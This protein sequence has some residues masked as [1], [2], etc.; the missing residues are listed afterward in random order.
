MVLLMIKENGD[1]Q[2]TR[3]TKL[4]LTIIIMG[5]S[6][7]VVALIIVIIVYSLGPWG[8]DDIDEKVTVNFSDPIIS[9]RHQH[10]VTLLDVD[11]QVINITPPGAIVRWE[12]VRLDISVNGDHWFSRYNQSLVLDYDPTRCETDWMVSNPV[13]CWYIDTQGDEETLNP[14]D[15]LRLTGFPEDYERVLIN[16][17]HNDMEL[18]FIAF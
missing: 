13:Q 1:Q 9:E 12:N 5:I 8:E 4:E 3:I 17:Y 2:K 16:V 15:M 11:F 18:Q 6:A 14:G 7:V 10:N